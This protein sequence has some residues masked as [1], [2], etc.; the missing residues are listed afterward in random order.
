M[1]DFK[2]F[3]DEI[4]ESLFE[5]QKTYSSKE[6]M[7]I[8]HSSRQTL[9]MAI[10]AQLIDKKE[11]TN[12]SRT[13]LIFSGDDI[14]TMYVVNSL[15][16]LGIKFSDNRLEHDDTVIDIFKKHDGDLSSII[17]DYENRLQD[18]TRQLDARMFVLSMIQNVDL[19]KFGFEVI[20]DLYEKMFNDLQKE[21]MD[22]DWFVVFD[23]LYEKIVDIVDMIK[24][25]DNFSADNYTEELKNCI[26][27]ENKP[28]EYLLFNSFKK[29]LSNNIIREKMIVEIG[30]EKFD[31]FM[32]LLDYNIEKYNIEKL[33]NVEKV[34]S[35][36]MP[37]IENAPICSE[38]KNLQEKS[39]DFTK[40]IIDR[41]TEK[42]SEQG[43]LFYSTQILSALNQNG[44]FAKKINSRGG[45]GTADKISMIAEKVYSDIYVDM[46]MDVLDVDESIFSDEHADIIIIQRLF[47]H[48]DDLIPDSSYDE[49]LM[50]VDMI[51]QCME[52]QFLSSSVPNDYWD[53]T[54]QR[55]YTH[56]KEKHKK[57]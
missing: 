56:V 27:A 6:V 41:Y 15:M 7:N 2:E 42:N 34:V 49:A 31:S 43:E 51:I 9:R 8:T 5:H 29:Y 37:V 11:D 36:L 48:L 32:S 46:I 17:K 12:K 40:Y 1:S 28:N 52:R 24:E 10:D 16:D 19:T 53:Y 54:K 14:L 20:V 26:A 35:Q 55:I 23:S 21:Q 22:K 39:E 4:R 25:D 38:A 47:D 13:Q 30:K 3:E 33:Y 57:M 44:N 45:D 50:V 18:R